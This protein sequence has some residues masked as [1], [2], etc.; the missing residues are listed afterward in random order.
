MSSQYDQRDRLLRVKDRGTNV[1][2]PLRG[3]EV[4]RMLALDEIADAQR[5]TTYRRRSVKVNLGPFT[6]F[7]GE[8]EEVDR[9]RKEAEG[10]GQDIWPQDSFGA[11]EFASRACDPGAGRCC[12]GHMFRFCL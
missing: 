10:Y 8:I 7:T 4:T 6:G 9:E 3:S 5:E 12:Y 1:P 2:E 11:G